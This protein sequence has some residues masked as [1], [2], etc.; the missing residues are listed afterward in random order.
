MDSTPNAIS[1]KSYAQYDQD[2]NVIDFYR[3]YPQGYFVDIGAFDG[4][5]LSNSY[6][7]ETELNWSGICVEPLPDK[8]QQLQS[9]RSATCVNTVLADQSGESVKFVR[10]KAGQSFLAGI[11]DKLDGWGKDR[12][13]R[14]EEIQLVTRTLTE[15]L[16]DQRAPSLI[17]FMSLDTE[18]GEL[19]IL[20]G[21]DFEKYTFGYICVEHNHVE[22]RRQEMRQILESNGY[23]FYRENQCD[24][25]YY[26]QSMIGGTYYYKNFFSAPI[27]VELIDG[28]IIK[29][30]SGYW[31]DQYGVFRPTKLE[32]EFDHFGT[33]RISA[34]SID[35][36]DGDSW[37]KHP[38]SLNHV[39]E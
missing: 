11:A 18:G 23:F 15:V 36:K 7:L 12:S 24:D 10:P 28:H 16:V 31:P 17:H 35:S 3:G 25:D 4:I 19:D 32:I 26:H 38:Q 33:R 9:R 29:A 34:C 22:S 8:F 39:I 20:K 1:N 30:S 2:L 37:R 13:L 14:G 6:K 5:F 27:E 21:I